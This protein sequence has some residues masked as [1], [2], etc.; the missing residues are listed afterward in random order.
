MS[1][2]NVEVV[3][4]FFEAVERLLEGWDTSRSVLEA[5]KAGDLPP[6]AREALGHMAS[7]AEWNPVFS[8]ETYRGQLEL[9]RAMEELLQAAG[10]YTLELRDLTDLGNDRVFAVYGI[11]LQGRT[12]GIQVG[13]G[14][15]SVVTVKD[16]LIARLDEFADRRE[17][18]EAAGLSE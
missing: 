7:D 13:V 11:N 9:G 1:Q 10:T 14:L 2:E 5:M 8:G 12:S 6:A 17:A 3:R 15:F 16:R 4:G 18:F